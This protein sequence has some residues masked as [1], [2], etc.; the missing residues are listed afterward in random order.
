MSN[1]LCNDCKPALKC[2]MLE[3]EVASLKNELVGIKKEVGELKTSTA[4]NEEQ[5]KMVFKIL[6]EIKD[7][8][9]KIAT[10]I[11]DIENRPSKLLWTV[12]G[13]LAGAL[14]VAGL[15]FIK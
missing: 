7:S 1:E 10:K 5:T 4:V 9:E 2:E 11:D 13:T 15:K 6:S 3:K 14:V 12:L 8:I